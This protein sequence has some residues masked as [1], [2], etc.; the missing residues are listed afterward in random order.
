MRAI[1]AVVLTAA[2]S[3]LGCRGG[4]NCVLDERADFGTILLDEHGPHR[5]LS[6]WCSIDGSSAAC[7]MKTEAAFCP[8]QAFELDLDSDP[9]GFPFGGHLNTAEASALRSACDPDTE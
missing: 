7:V 3:V 8:T 9:I 5:F 4:A 6:C 1:P 2:L